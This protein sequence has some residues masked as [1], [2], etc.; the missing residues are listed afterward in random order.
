MN[1]VLKKDRERCERKLCGGRVCGRT[2]GDGVRMGPGPRATRFLC[3]SWCSLTTCMMRLGKALW[4]EKER[5]RERDRERG[6]SH[7]HVRARCAGGWVGVCVC[8]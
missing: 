6:C 1:G 5:E 4:R 7:A 2:D 3:R 8:V